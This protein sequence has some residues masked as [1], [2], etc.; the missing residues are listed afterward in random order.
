VAVLA[1]QMAVSRTSCQP[2]RSPSVVSRST[3]AA[4]S[5]APMRSC[6][7]LGRSIGIAFASKA[8]GSLPAIGES[9]SVFVNTDAVFGSLPPP[10]D[11]ASLEAISGWLY[12]KKQVTV[13][14]FRVGENAPA[15]R[16]D[17]AGAAGCSAVNPIRSARRADRCSSSAG[18]IVRGSDR[19]RFWRTSL[20]EKDR[21]D[22]DTADGHELALPVLE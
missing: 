20:S 14:S 18:V 16:S 7:A 8:C 4:C 1:S 21:Q 11:Q 12:F 19:L 22:N 5:T 10:R 13:P 3:S 9:I 6:S 17:L 2:S 15:E